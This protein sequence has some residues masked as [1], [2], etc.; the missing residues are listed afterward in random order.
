MSIM[1]S[2]AKS[3]LDA[4]LHAGLAALPERSIAALEGITI[5]SRG[6]SIGVSRCTTARVVELP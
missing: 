2:L 1:P 4:E 5:W 3:L 6:T